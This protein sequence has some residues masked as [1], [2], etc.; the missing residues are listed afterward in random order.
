MKGSLAGRLLRG[1]GSV[2]LMFCL[3]IFGLI[4]VIAPGLAFNLGFIFLRTA[5]EN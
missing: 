4:F 1:L 3:L 5:E 2:C